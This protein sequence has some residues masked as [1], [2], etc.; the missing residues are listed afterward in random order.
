M[1]E[2]NPTE[3]ATGRP[4]S[5]V[6]RHIAQAEL[7]EIENWLIDLQRRTATLNIEAQEVIRGTAIRLYDLQ[8]AVF[9]MVAD[10]APDKDTT[11]RA[12]RIVFGHGLAGLYAGEVR[13]A[14]AA[15]GIVEQGA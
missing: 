4:M 15:V 3:P 5:A 10:T 12:A 6:E 11:D 7:F 1:A 13:D 2:M 9:D 8:N 14:L